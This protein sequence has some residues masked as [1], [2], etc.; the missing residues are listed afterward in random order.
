M[1]G[2]DAP[3]CNLKGHTTGHYLSG[4]ALCY[5][6]GK[7]GRIREKACYMIR[8]LGKCQDAFA[9]MPGIGEG[10]LSGYTEEQFDKLEKYT[11]YPDIWAPYYTLHKILAGLLDCYE[12][13]GIDQAFE[14]AQ[15]LGMWVYRRQIGRASCRERV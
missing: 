15:K 5:K 1:T 3:E 13:A 8:E 11:P 4:L 12:F 6:A 14:V 10:F 2:W 9:C 7:D